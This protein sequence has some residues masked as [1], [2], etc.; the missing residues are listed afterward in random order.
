MTLEEKIEQITGNDFKTKGNKRLGIPELVMTD[1]PVGP[2]GKG[3][4]LCI[5]H[6]LTGEQHGI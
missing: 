5:Q 3:L 4:Q 2:R 1:G 6:L